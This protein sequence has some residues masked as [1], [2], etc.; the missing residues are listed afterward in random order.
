MTRRSHAGL[1]LLGVAVLGGCGGGGDAA[2][3]RRVEELER[4]AAVSSTTD[5][6]APATTTSSI[7]TSS[8]PA[9]TA[10]ALSTTAAGDPA[11]PD[12]SAEALT[13]FKG[14]EARCTTEPRVEPKRFTG[15]KVAGRLSG[16]RYAIRD[17]AGTR[18]IVDLKRKVVTGAGGPQGVMPRPYSFACPPELYEGTLDE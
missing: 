7:A 9:T 6:A 14:T 15:A 3:E 12:R 8:V 18:L 4:R 1:F 2:L 11:G 5:P 13:F 10:A 16:D 17:G